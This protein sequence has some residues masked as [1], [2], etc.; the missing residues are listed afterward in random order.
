MDFGQKK[1][2]RE[3][4]LVDF[5]CFLVWNLLNFLAHSE[6]IAVFLTELESMCSKHNKNCS[7]SRYPFLCSLKHNVGKKRQP[8]YI[9]IVFFFFFF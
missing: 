2:F 4:D 5:T 9:F 6:L 8:I 3:I 7:T 1:F